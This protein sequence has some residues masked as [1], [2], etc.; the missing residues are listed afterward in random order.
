MESSSILPL[1]HHHR[2]VY[3]HHQHQTIVFQKKS[4]DD[5]EEEKE[6][7]YSPK[8]MVEPKST[9]TTPIPTKPSNQKK[10]D[11]DPQNHHRRLHDDASKEIEHDMMTDLVNFNRNDILTKWSSLVI[12]RY[13]HILIA[14]EKDPLSWSSTL[15]S[16]YVQN[17]FQPTL[18][19][20]L[21]LVCT[22][23]S[24]SSCSS[25]ISSSSS[26]LEPTKHDSKTTTI[27]ETN[28]L[29]VLLRQQSIPLSTLLQKGQI[30]EEDILTKGV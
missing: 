17:S 30:S 14:K 28:L 16:S 12:K 9:N 29:D 5:D 19:K 18:M 10:H 21:D 27:T 11:N 23:S 3:H 22:S 7:E 20:I 4:N 25:Q 15:I 2:H 24:S 8:P 26:N 1:Y 6:E 13:C